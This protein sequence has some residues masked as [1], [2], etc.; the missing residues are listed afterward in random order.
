V[1]FYNVGKLFIIRKIVIRILELYAGKV[2]L[3]C[4]AKAS[5]SNQMQSISLW[6]QI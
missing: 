4:K 3:F 2:E 5:M 6:P 1:C